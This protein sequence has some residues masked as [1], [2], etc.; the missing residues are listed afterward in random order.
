M[1]GAVTSGAFSQVTPLSLLRT[2]DLYTILL[3]DANKFCWRGIE[4]ESIRLGLEGEIDAT[5]SVEKCHLS[6]LG[7]K[8]VFALTERERSTSLRK[9][10]RHGNRS[11][12]LG[13]SQRQ[14]NDNGP[15]QRHAV[16]GVDE[17]LRELLEG[18]PD[19]RFVY[20][21]GGRLGLPTVHQ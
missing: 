8:R 10:L 2:A 9:H 13:R 7:D 12:R 1:H 4:R 18:S 6:A 20:G 5:T 15:G 17:R 16:R 21:R 14:D 11:I 19:P 3:S